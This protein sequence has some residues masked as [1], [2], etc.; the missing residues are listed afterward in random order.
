[1]VQFCRQA[2]ASLK[3][4]GSVCDESN[5]EINLHCY[6]MELKEGMNNSEGWISSKV[7]KLEYASAGTDLAIF[8]VLLTNKIV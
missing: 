6:A 2:V 1:M 8:S 3:E 4:G 7:G 5:K